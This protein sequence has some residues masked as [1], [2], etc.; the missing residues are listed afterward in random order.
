MKDGR[1]ENVEREVQK[2]RKSR[3]SAVH[4]TVDISLSL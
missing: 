4:N 1:E 3:W 2:Q